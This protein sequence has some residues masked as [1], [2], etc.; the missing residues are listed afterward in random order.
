MPEKFEHLYLM[1]QKLIG[2]GHLEL[3][4]LVRLY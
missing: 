1:L 2:L 3:L 4:L